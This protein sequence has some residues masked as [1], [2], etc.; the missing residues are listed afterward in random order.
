[1]SFDQAIA[2]MEGQISLLSL[3]EDAREG[4]AAFNE[5][6]KAGWTGR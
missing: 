3:T 2:Y 1:M 4:M 6:R 5:K